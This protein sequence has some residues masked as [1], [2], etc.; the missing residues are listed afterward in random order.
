MEGE[1]GG[2]ELIREMELLL[3]KCQGPSVFKDAFPE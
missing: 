1:G 3:R 2:T